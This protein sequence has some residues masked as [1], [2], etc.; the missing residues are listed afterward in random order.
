MAA[1][2][3]TAADL[4]GSYRPSR[5]LRGLRARAVAQ[6]PP[7]LVVT[8]DE[9]EESLAAL[10]CEDI[11][12]AVSAPV[13][14]GGAVILRTSRWARRAPS[15]TGWPP[16]P[17]QHCGASPLGVG[18]T[19]L[20]STYAA[21]VPWWRS[22][23][24]PTP[25][26]TPCRA[27]APSPAAALDAALLRLTAELDAPAGTPTAAAVGAPW[28]PHVAALLAAVRAIVTCEGGGAL[29]P[30]PDAPAARRL[31]RLVAS[32][33]RCGPA[34]RAA[35]SPAAADALLILAS[36][37][38]SPLLAGAGGAVAAAAAAR[39][40]VD[41]LAAAGADLH[42]PLL[43]VTP[44]VAAGSATA[45]TAAC[46]ACASFL[47]HAAGPGAG[48]VALAAAAA[49]ALAPPTATRGGPPPLHRPPTRADAAALVS[50]NVLVAIEAVI[51]GAL[52]LRAAVSGGGQGGDHRP[53][54]TKPLHAAAHTA[55]DRAAAAA[56]AQAMLVAHAPAAWPAVPESGGASLLAT[57]RKVWV[58]EA[59]AAAAAA[60]AGGRTTPPP[61]PPPPSPRSPLDVAAD[62]D[63]AA[64]DCAGLDTALESR[65]DAATRA[66]C[67]LVCLAAPASCLR[68][69]GSAGLSAATLQLL[70]LVTGRAVS[71]VERG[72]RSEAVG[73]CRLLAATAAALAT[74]GAG[75]A[76]AA[77]GAADVL[78]HAARAALL[79][80]LLRREV[81]ETVI[82]GVAARAN[83]RRTSRPPRR[84][85]WSALHR[86]ASAVSLADELSSADELSEGEEDACGPHSPAGA[87]TSDGDLIGFPSDASLA[88]SAVSDSHPTHDLTCTDAGDG[89]TWSECG[90]PP[91]RDAAAAVRRAA[92]RAARTAARREAVVA[93]A[94]YE[95]LDVLTS[96][97]ALAGRSLALDCGIVTSGLLSVAAAA[98]PPAWDD[99][100]ACSHHADTT[101]AA[102]ARMVL[103]LLDSLG[104]EFEDVRRVELW[105]ARAVTRALVPSGGHFRRC[106]VGAMA[107]LAHRGDRPLPRHAD[108]RDPLPAVAAAAAALVRAFRSPTPSRRA[109]LVLAAPGHENVAIA[110]RRSGA[111]VGC[112]NYG[113]ANLAGASEGEAAGEALTGGC[114][115]PDCSAAAYCSTACRAAHAPDHVD[116]CMAAGEEPEKRC[117][118][119][120]RK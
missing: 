56:E 55:A 88:S 106:Y 6:A 83:T 99:G 43:A 114:S 72:G 48:A 26:C 62:E 113:C 15:P 14:V 89:V 40:A 65:A 16:T 5:A 69:N 54:A 42:D 93:A 67:V 22:E 30:P 75:H 82:D 90:S 59:A 45:A 25:P 24:T 32:W 111:L 100:G 8:A 116:A 68:S 11:N 79:D 36:V 91:R 97:S 98:A 96:L 119:S 110:A 63:D 105:C 17:P 38:E 87:S 53:S 46:R 71:A 115:C 4:K 41:A 84:S 64:S 1:V 39:V 118:S 49:G 2:N 9:E 66:A 50:A 109:A 61:R 28:S 18:G 103:N 104:W 78:A 51:R 60:A 20:A 23:P 13:P 10:S 3:M 117:C 58:A 29:A 85:P 57:L 101:K 107:A 52:K 76:V 19:S 34:Q 27:V 47:A 80:A 73:V 74:A 120:R 7:P 70:P 37:M 108:W 95:L 12:H 92:V 86:S 33:C 102:F 112:A 44:G 77:C 94:E 31:A 35:A 81:P 21:A